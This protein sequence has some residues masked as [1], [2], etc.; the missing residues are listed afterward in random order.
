MRFPKWRMHVAQSSYAIVVPCLHNMSRKRPAAHMNG[1]DDDAA[2]LHRQL[3]QC[4]TH[5]GVVQALTALHAAGKL[6]N[7][8]FRPRQ[9]AKSLTKAKQEH[10]NHV[11]S[12]GRVA[13]KMY[14]GIDAL[15]YWDY[16]NPLAL[17]VYL[18]SISLPFFEIM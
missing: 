3:V 9:L 8:K 2:P 17:L 16:C 4:S 18:S 15:P 14:L 12:Y 11:T 6:S 13:C 1:G 10:S 7:L 5:T